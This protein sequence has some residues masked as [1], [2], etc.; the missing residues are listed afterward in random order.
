M[1]HPLSLYQ[2]MEIQDYFLHQRGKENRQCRKNTS[3]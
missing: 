3:Q 2:K 1:P